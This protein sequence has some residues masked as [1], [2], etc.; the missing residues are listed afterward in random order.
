MA[1]VYVLDEESFAER[2]WDLPFVATVDDLRKVVGGFRLATALEMAKWMAGPRAINMP[3]M[4][5]AEVLD[6]LGQQSKKSVV[7]G[8]AERQWKLKEEPYDPDARDGDGDGIVQEGTAWERPA[9]TRFVRANG[10]E[11]SAG[12]MMASRPT[13]AK[14]VDADGNEVAREWK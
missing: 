6:W 4:L 1:K 7:L 11:I 5:R 3:D 14:L 13:S 9:G 12:L 2:A 10:R 8:K